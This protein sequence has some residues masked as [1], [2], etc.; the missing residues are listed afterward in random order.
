MNWEA[1]WIFFTGFSS[2]VMFFSC[3]A[4]TPETNKKHIKY[5]LLLLLG[6]AVLGAICVGL[7][8]DEMLKP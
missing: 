3:G 8:A 6:A 4:L 5:I 2:V 7:S 1:F